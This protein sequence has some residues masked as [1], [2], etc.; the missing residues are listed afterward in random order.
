MRKSQD[1][2][3]ANSINGGGVAGDLIRAI[4]WSEHEL[5][6]PSSWPQSL[7]SALSICLNSNFAIAIYWGPN[8]ILLYNEPWSPIPG[9][10][11]PWAQGKPARQVWPEI[12][13]DIEPQFAKAFTGTP[14]GSKDALLPMQRHGYTEE[15]YFDFTFTPIY[16]E[17]GKVEGV[18]NAV[19]ETTYRVIGERRSSL[20][21]HLTDT[22]NKLTTDEE[23][24][25]RAS[26]ILDGAKK[27]ISFYYIYEFD[28]T[29][30]PILRVTS[31]DHQNTNR[32]WPLRDAINGSTKRVTDI[33]HFFTTIPAGAW[34]EPPHEALILP[35]KRNNG[36][37]FGCIVGGISSRRKHDKDYRLFYD[38]V[39]SI[40]GGELNTIRS[41]N[42]ERER[43]EALAQIDHA[44][45]VF[46]A[47]ISHE[48]RTPL[49][50]MLSPLESVIDSNENS[51]EQR[52]NLSTSYRNTLRLQKLVNALLDFSRIEA[53][54]M[55]AKFEAVR[56]T[57]LT[58][59]VSSS[60]R[61][62]VEAAGIEFKVNL[63]PIV[64]PVYL[65]P[66]MWEKIILNLLSNAFK[67]TE[68]GSI[69]IDLSDLDDHI[70]FKVK[71]TG[72]GIKEEHLP[73]I[74]DRFYRIDNAGGRSQE[75]TG[76]GLAMVKELVH[77]HD[78]EISVESEYGKGSVFSVRIPRKNRR[79]ES[80]VPSDQINGSNI[81]YVFNEGDGQDVAHEQVS[82]GPTVVVADDN[83]D[84]R[85]YILRLLRESFR[86]YGAKNGE[87]AFELALTL[88]PDLI[89]CDIMMPKLDGFGLLKKMKSNLALRN[90]PVIFLSARA[91]EEARVEGI[92]AGAD[93][94]LVKP[95]SAKELLARVRNHIAINE[96]RTKTEREFFDLFLQSPIHIHV[97]SGPEHVVE[98]F[99]PL[100]KKIIGRDITGLKIRDAL[101]EVEGQGYFEMLDQVYQ[102]GKRISI[103]E[104]K[105]MVL[106]PDGTPEEYVF[107]ITYLPWRGVDGNI[108]GVLQFTL[109]VTEES[110]TFQKIRESEEKF[111][112][113]AN[114]IPQFVW[115]ADTKGTIEFLSDRWEFY[116]GMAPAEGRNLFSTLIHADDITE[117][118]SRWFESME[119][120]TPWTAEFR[121]LDTRTGEYRWFFGHTRP[122]LNEKGEV[123]RWIGSSSDIHEQ[124]GLNERLEGLVVERTSEL[125]KL[126]RLLQRKN[127]EFLKT[128]IFLKT[129]LD[130]SVELV[131]AFDNNLNFTFINSRLKSFTSKTPEELIGRNLL[132]VVPGFEKTEGYEHLQR[133]L[134]G[135]T[136]HIKSPNPHI[137]NS[138]FFETFV[139][140][141]KRDEVITG[142]VTMQRDIT[143]IIKLT[144]DLKTSNERLKS[145]NED[146]QRFAH[147]TSHDLKEP[148][149]KVKMYGDILRNDYSPFLPDQGIEYLNRIEKATNRISSMIDGVLKYSSVEAFDQE[150]IAIDLDK[151]IESIM[152]DIEILIEESGAEINFEELPTI[153][154]AP[155]LIYQ[156]FFNLITNAIKF[157]RKEVAPRIA[158]TWQLVDTPDNG[159]QFFKV[160]LS[161]NGIGFEQAFADKIFESFARL[162][163][164]DTFEGTGLGLSLCRKIVE[165]H[166]G[167]I[168]AV[169]QPGV[170]ATFVIY[171]PKKILQR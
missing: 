75:G 76:I 133:G 108:K 54:R 67:Y 118:R 117:V 17:S 45:T 20:L 153:L 126:N 119:K 106:G 139:I 79:V 143:D 144:E 128:Q 18:F 92:R 111:R 113:L 110:R 141:L 151:V 43:A 115:I 148:V 154:G 71:D 36:Q 40:I 171:L 38:S 52:E 160:E 29:H 88:Q 62:A 59:D 123:V 163:P 57:E 46:F 42:Q 169:G 69:E 22:L 150:F 138:L 112:L 147:T 114:A 50:L 97:F 19:V 2:E 35:L 70:I 157:R 14:G 166:H 140:P 136:I 142:V 65:D 6:A 68:Q 165:R 105:A 30:N 100:G 155:T 44:K 101:P 124:K 93:D 21:Q 120:V 122:L 24:F 168:D 121:L 96:M 73:K 158:I 7:K 81:G 129:V 56:L 89:V 33:S 80:I 16:G 60:F 8:L 12:W 48:F 146:L 47:N 116:T 15:C 127:E 104:A 82:T 132:D 1:A 28:A 5:G 159:G 131:T 125:R 49:A 11:H 134:R 10:K 137:N 98:F 149:R 23:V 61:S 109:D 66:D 9:N 34:P 103:P 91:G 3:N 152:E 51:P 95:F 161:D 84:M 72:V 32:E 135:E 39:A 99:H 102:E 167:R 156:L 77:M 94:Y 90:T 58:R 41:I 13:E 27:D 74:F 170:G 83:N 37:V 31:E 164:K 26:E 25:D 64:G 162:H 145:S 53:G 86:V 107:N 63:E 55:D 85:N 87:E 78:G 4:N 130:S